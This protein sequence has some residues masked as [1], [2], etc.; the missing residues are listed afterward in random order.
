[1]KIEIDQISKSF[2]TVHA[3]VGVSLAVDAGTIHGLLGENGAGKTTL[4][5]I[6]SRL[7]AAG[8]GRDPAS[9]GG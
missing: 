3:N 6:L 4:M 8:R 7:S 5:K 9:T 2:G 1:M